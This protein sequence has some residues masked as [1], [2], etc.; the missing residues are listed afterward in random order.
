M[1]ETQYVKINKLKTFKHLGKSGI[2]LLRKLDEQF[3]SLNSESHSSRNVDRVSHRNFL[4]LL[5]VLVI[6][7]SGIFC[8]VATVPG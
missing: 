8:H 5:F 7:G 1:E 6:L 4:H 3:Y 2:I